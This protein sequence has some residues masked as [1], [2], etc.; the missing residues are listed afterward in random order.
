MKIYIVWEYYPH[1]GGCVLEV[2]NNKASAEKF[3]ET[4]TKDR[5]AEYDVEERDVRS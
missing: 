1:E 4:Y 5:Y 3:L 2:F